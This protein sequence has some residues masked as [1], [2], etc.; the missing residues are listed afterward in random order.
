MSTAAQIDEAALRRYLEATWG[1]VCTQYDPEWIVI[2]D[3]MHRLVTSE[4]KRIAELDRICSPAG[5]R[6]LFP[7]LRE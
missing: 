6:S 7:G 4:M 1:E 5:L 2:E 3:T